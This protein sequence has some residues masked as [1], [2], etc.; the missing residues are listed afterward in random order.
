[1]EE[2]VLETSL[3]STA[4]DLYASRTDSVAI[5]EMMFLRCMKGS[6]LAYGMIT[7]H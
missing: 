7:L 4:V 2:P 3:I 6:E 5:D 1:M